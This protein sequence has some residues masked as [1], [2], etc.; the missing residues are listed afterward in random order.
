MIKSMTGFGRAQETIDNLIIT[1][2]IKSVNHRYFDFSSRV[3][4]IYGFIEEKLKSHIQS[5]VSRGKVECYVQIE[6]Q[7]AEECI[8]KVNHS[9]AKGAGTCVFNI[10][11]CDGILTHK[12]ECGAY[13]TLTGGVDDGI[14]LCMNTSAQL[15]SLTAGDV[16]C[17]PDAVT[18]VDAV[19]SASGCTHIACGYNLVVVDNN[20]TEIASEAGASLQNGFCYIEIIVFLIYS[21]HNY[22]LPDKFVKS[23][24]F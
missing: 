6:A 17:F 5:S 20:G 10:S 22:D 19:F 3:P 21:D 16:V 8:V 24:Y 14:L 4:R 7:E 12:V 1:V 11:T 9:L 23:S 18:K 13:H 2:E 15:V